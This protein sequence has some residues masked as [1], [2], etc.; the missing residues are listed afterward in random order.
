AHL[1]KAA[2]NPVFAVLKRPDEKQVTEA[3]YEN[4][5][6]VED[7]VRDLTLLLDAD[8]RITWLSINSE[9]FESIHNHNAYAQLTRDKRGGG[10]I[11]L[12][13]AVLRA[14]RTTSR[15]ADLPHP[16]W[17]APRRRHGA[18]AG[19]ALPGVVRWSVTRRAPGPR[20]RRRN[21]LPCSTPRVSNR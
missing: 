3:A 7:I 11:G 6:F 20:S 2:S 21:R 16:Q 8:E 14:R 10:E 18:P 19:A 4:P 13:D 5:K 1:E 15:S 17:R 9:Y 12:A